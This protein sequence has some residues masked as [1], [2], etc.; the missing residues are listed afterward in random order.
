[1]TGLLATFTLNVPV[2]AGYTVARFELEP[3]P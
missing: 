2:L 3:G 1:M